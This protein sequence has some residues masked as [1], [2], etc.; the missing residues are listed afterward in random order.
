IDASNPRSIGFQLAELARHI[1]TLPQSG[2]GAGRIEEQRIALFLLS[3]VRGADLLSL[4]MPGPDGARTALQKLLN[5]AASSLAGLSD[6]TAR[7]YCSRLEGGV[8][9]A[10]ARWRDE[11]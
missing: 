5:E 8:K 3:S 1:D 2:D 10:R 9:W 6:L 4:A 11:P 7:A